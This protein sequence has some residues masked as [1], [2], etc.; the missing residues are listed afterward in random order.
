MDKLNAYLSTT[1]NISTDETDLYELANLAGVHM[2][3][4]IFK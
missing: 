1:S 2:D 3:Q 4:K